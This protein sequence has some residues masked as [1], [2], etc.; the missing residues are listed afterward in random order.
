[1]QLNLSAPLT[2]FPITHL[3]GPGRRFALFVQGCP[4]LCTVD[5]L[6]ADELPV[7]DRHLYDVDVVANFIL[8]LR[9][10]YHIEGITLLGGEPFG[11]PEALSELCQ[12][13]KSHGL[14]VMTYSGYSAH[15]LFNNADSAW[16]SLLEQTDIL[17]EGPFLFKQMSNRILWRGSANQRIL[18]LSDA[19]SLDELSQKYLQDKQ[20]S[21]INIFEPYHD[22]FEVHWSS[23]ISLDTQRIND[24]SSDLPD[25]VHLWIPEAEA[26]KQQKYHVRKGLIAVVRDNKTLLYGYQDRE[27]RDRFV[28]NLAQLGIELA[29]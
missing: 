23:W 27:T 5:C 22:G 2:D 25:T 19:Y 11:Q 10:H 15:R 13:V 28:N 24:K 1:M 7:E 9:D 26:I 14:T 17:V 3:S 21:S 6:N 4:L 16:Q 20:Q 18:L 29:V 8:D 12:R